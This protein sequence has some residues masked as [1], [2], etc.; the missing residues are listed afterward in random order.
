[1]PKIN[2]LDPSVYNLISAGEVVERP[3]SIVKE[4]V[5]NSIDAGATEI[6]IELTDGG[7]TS[8]VVADNGIGIA[9]DDLD[10]CYLP[11]T[12]SKIK[13]AADLDDISTLGFRGEALASITAVAQVKISTKTLDKEVGE[14][15]QIDGGKVVDKGQIGAKQGT[16]IQV[17]NIFFNTPVR[18]K[19]LK[20][21]KQEESIVSSVVTE[22]I[23]A[24]PDIKFTYS[25][26]GKV[27]YQTNGGLENAIY[28]I[29]S[30]DIANKMIAFDD[31]YDS[32]RVYGYTGDK[33]L[34]KHN[35]SF[36]TTIVNGRTITNTTIQTAVM[37]AYGN[38]LMKRCYP[39]YILNII[40]PFEDVDVNVHPNKKEVRFADNQ[41]IFSRVYHAISKA[42]ATQSSSMVIGGYKVE[43]SDNQTN[44]DNDF[45]NSAGQS[46]ANSDNPNIA[47]NVDSSN[48]SSKLQQNVIDSINESYS[49][50]IDNLEQID[51]K[52]QQAIDAQQNLV[53]NIANSS[54]FADRKSFDRLSDNLT[55]RSPIMSTKSDNQYDYTQSSLFEQ[56]EKTLAPEYKIVGQLFDTYLILE[57]GEKAFV[58]DQHACHER[59][60]YDQLIEKVDNSQ[61]AR[62][63]MLIPYIIECNS[64]QYEYMNNILDI[65]TSFGFDI[66]E[67][68]GL[69]FKVDAIPSLLSN[70]N[71]DKFFDDILNEKN[72]TAS[73]KKSDLIKDNLA[74]LA[75]KSAIKAGDRLNDAQIRSLVDNMNKGIPMQCP[76]GRPTVI[77]VT[78]TQLDKLFKRIV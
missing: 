46:L 35:R 74:Q 56:I 41:R 61:V 48:I 73:L 17:D 65:L 18:R 64:A 71:L 77:E 55:M 72:F 78:R 54:S 67:F 39:V 57:L 30:T 2:I 12:T 13:V 23:F 58:I 4:L 26:D 20:K 34:S 10:I 68:G 66:Q 16:K 25:C 1:M 63:T 21:P 38:I 43:L 31:T 3:A 27:V 33:T 22:L 15:I 62:Q 53:G 51:P 52:L 44:N 11:H 14:Y 32:I 49:Q 24:N 28:A 60:L 37:Q 76:H 69:S 19:F 50:N 59:I 45:S 9:S 47:N 7:L 8:I 70:I 42:L 29:Y 36:Q 75:C 5:E 6:D 40:M